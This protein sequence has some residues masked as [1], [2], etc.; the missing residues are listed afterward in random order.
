MALAPDDPARAKLAALRESGATKDEILGAME[1]YEIPATFFVKG[2]SA[3]HAKL[4][5]SQLQQHMVET[6]VDHGLVVVS[7][8][9]EPVEQTWLKSLPKLDG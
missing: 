8:I 4:L 5:L 6:H 9:G 2:L 7:G 1:T 3:G